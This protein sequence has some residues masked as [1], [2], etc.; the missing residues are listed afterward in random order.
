MRSA[1]AG[2]RGELAG[3][4]KDLGKIEIVYADAGCLRGR[5]SRFFRTLQMISKGQ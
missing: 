2:G 4:P 3:P 1:R 5:T